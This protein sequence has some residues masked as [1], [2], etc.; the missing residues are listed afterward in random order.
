MTLHFEDRI[1]ITF[2]AIGPEAANRVKTVTEKFL[3]AT[4]TLIKF[5]SPL[6]IPT[7]KVKAILV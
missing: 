6:T 7:N 5:V 1:P 2:H 4:T 3:S